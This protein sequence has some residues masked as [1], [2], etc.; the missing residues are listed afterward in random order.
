[1]HQNSTRGRVLI[2][3]DEVWVAELLKCFFTE[4][5]YESVIAEDGI[6]AEALLNKGEYSLIITDVIFFQSGGIDLINAIRHRDKT[7]PIIVVTGFGPEVAREAM[8][9][10]ANDFILKP[11]NFRQIKRKIRKFIDIDSTEKRFGLVAVK[12]GFITPSQLSDAL[13]VQVMEDVEK[14]KHRL[15]GKILLEQRLIT[16]PQIDV[17]IESLGKCYNGK[18]IHMKSEQ[19]L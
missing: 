13:K 15:L 5:N 9:A 2:V 1:M 3:E 8:K 7:V 11:F 18:W 10:G 12:K 6:E 17:V 14:G 16:T 4:H 19:P